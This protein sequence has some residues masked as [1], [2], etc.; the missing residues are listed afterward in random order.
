VHGGIVGIGHTGPPSVPL[1]HEGSRIGEDC[2]NADSVYLL[3]RRREVVI[4]TTDG[5][6]RVADVPGEA[7]SVSPD[8]VVA[9]RAMTD[10][11]VSLS[12]G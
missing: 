2:S 1:N 9:N 11:L 10:R 8:L 12:L 6:R 7:Y 4:E 3:A 5:G